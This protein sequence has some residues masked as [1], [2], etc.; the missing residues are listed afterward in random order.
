MMHYDDLVPMLFSISV[1]AY[2]YGRRRFLVPPV[3]MFVFLMAAQSGAPFLATALFGLGLAL[4]VVLGM[5]RPVY[6][7]P[8]GFAALWHDIRMLS[9]GR[10]R[11]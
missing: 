10:T 5:D 11:P 9:Q 8:A 4:F 6:I 2:F 7:G 1:S 3:T